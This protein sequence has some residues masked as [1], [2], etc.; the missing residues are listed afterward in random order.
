MEEVRVT[1]E[2]YKGEMQS[3]KVGTPNHHQKARNLSIP[4]A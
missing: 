3:S 2:V 1:L 4:V